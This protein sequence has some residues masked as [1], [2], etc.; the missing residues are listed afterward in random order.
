MHDPYFDHR[1]HFNV[2]PAW[3]RVAHGAVAF[4]TVAAFLLAALEPVGDGAGEGAD[5]RQI[6]STGVFAD[7]QRTNR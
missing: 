3:V 6:A 1:Y 2:F 7:Q 4:L 5:A